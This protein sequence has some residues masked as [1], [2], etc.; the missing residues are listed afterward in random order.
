MKR[1]PMTKRLF[2]ALL[3]VGEINA[4]ETARMLDDGLPPR[5]CPPGLTEAYAEVRAAKRASDSR[6]QKQDA[7]ESRAR[8]SV[9]RR[10]QRG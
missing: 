9:R 7:T 10:V 2:S 5:E 8:R 1:R 6:T 4:T 3:R